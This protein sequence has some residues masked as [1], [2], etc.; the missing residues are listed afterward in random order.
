M[1]EPKEKEM[2]KYISRIKNVAKKDYATRRWQWE[3]LGRKGEAPDK[4]DLGSMGGQAV[5]WEINKILY[6]NMYGPKDE[7]FVSLLVSIYEN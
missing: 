4:G 7:S 2:L 3:K 1:H 6:G 5:R